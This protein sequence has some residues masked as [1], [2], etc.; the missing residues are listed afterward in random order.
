MDASAFPDTRLPKGMRLSKRGL[1]F[2][3]SRGLSLLILPGRN[4][5]ALNACGTNVVFFDPTVADIG[6]SKLVKITQNT[7]KY[8]EE[9]AQQPFILEAGPQNRKEMVEHETP[10][11]DLS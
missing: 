10:M 2:F 8:E 6:E 9:K 4:P 3:L 1:V 11:D 5:S 7:L